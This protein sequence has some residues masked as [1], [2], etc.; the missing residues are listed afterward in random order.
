MTPPPRLSLG[1]A[2]FLDFDGTLV[3]LRDDPDSA[4]LTVREA[5]TLLALAAALKGALAVVS[6]RALDDLSRR[7][8]AGLTRIGSHGLELAAPGAAATRRDTSPAA[9]VAALSGVVGQFPGTRLEAKGPV[10]AVH[11]RAAPNLRVPL[12]NA[13]GMAV[14]EVPG[15]ALHGGKMVYEAKPHGADKGAALTRTMR[16][17]AFNGRRPVMVGD[18]TTDEDGFAAAAA[19]GGHGI[20]VGPG[21]T[22][23]RYRLSAPPGVWTW[24]V[25][26]G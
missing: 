18:D 24:L 2:L 26:P 12:G 8:P 7:V 17:G 1:D 16:D 21:P 13:L 14:A 9:L 6:G 11:Y 10:L 15:Y 22:A 5:E 4:E 20:K 23:A 19:L 25:D 3:G